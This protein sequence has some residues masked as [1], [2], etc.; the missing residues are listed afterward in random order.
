MNNG[1]VWHNVTMS[2][3]SSLSKEHLKQLNQDGLIIL[4]DLIPID[5]IHEIKK[6][7]SSWF[8][9]ISFN[10]RISSS[11]VGSNQWIE[12]VGLCSF[13]A[14]QVALDENLINFLK[15]YFESEIS[16]GSIQIQKKIFSEKG[17]PLHSDLGNGLGIF[18]YLTEPDAKY[19]ATEFVKKSHM[20]K[21]DE[22]YKN[23][24]KIDDA[25]YINLKKSPFSENDIIKTHGGIGTLVIFH[26]SIWHQLPR[27][28]NP[29]REIIMIRYNNTETSSNDHLIKNSF[30]NLLSPLQKEVFLKN[31]SDKTSPSLGGLGSYSDEPDVYKIPNWKMLLYFI[32]YKLFSKANT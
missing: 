18:I 32:K 15:K 24:N 4:P 11:I 21:I 23:K 3:F 17:I 6:D 22:R 9:Y 12:H 19:G 7:T 29:G 20:T 30:L 1:M 26:R 10:N 16:L 31:S 8:K 25:T 14:L 13:K 27:F 2:A 5:I 28:S